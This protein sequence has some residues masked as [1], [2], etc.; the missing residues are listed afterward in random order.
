MSKRSS[1]PR[2]AR[3]INLYLPSS[4]MKQAWET[5]AKSRAL[6]LTELIVGSVQ[7]FFA[8]NDDNQPDT[9]QLEERIRNQDQEIR[10]LSQDKH[11]LEALVDYLDQELRKC[12]AEP[13]Q[14]LQREGTRSFDKELIDLL[15][16]NAEGSGK[17]KALTD[18]D[19]F[20]KLR[21]DP[22]QT[23]EVKAISN[24]LKA[25]QRWGL[26]QYSPAGWRWVR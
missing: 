1:E 23:Y 8:K 4:T 6:T 7:R 5:E 26:I 9:R 11:R 2:N 22:R 14:E 13:W 15:K 20:T 3:R 18:E 24:Q 19:I 21:I 16:S 12:R 10:K 17:Q 25:L